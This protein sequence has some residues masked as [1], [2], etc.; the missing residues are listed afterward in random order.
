MF[1]CFSRNSTPRWIDRWISAAVGGSIGLRFRPH[2]GRRRR[3]RRG[4]SSSAQAGRQNQPPAAPV[5]RHRN[6]IKSAFHPAT[7]LPCSGS[8]TT[9]ALVKPLRISTCL[10]VFRPRVTGRSLVL[11]SF[12]NTCTE[13]LCSSNS[14]VIMAFGGTQSASRLQIRDQL[15]FAGHAGHE[16][17]GLS[18]SS[19]VSRAVE[20]AG[21]NRNVGHVVERHGEV[22]VGIAGG[23]GGSL[24]PGAKIGQLILRD[25]RAD[26]HRPR[27]DHGHHHLVRLNGAV[28]A[29]GLGQRRRNRRLPPHK[30]AV[31]HDSVGRRRRRSST[32]G[33]PAAD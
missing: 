25:R 5:H 19:T 23:R 9:F 21:R 27:L 3:R 12:S 18:L 2:L 11:P 1:W 20:I 6:R 13:C 15:H 7:F 17:L 10:S 30:L 29:E 32:R 26:E 31:I 14:S 16:Q 22:Q 4:G 33:R 8:S 24:Q 28:A